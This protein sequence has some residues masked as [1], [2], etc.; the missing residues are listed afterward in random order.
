MSTPPAPLRRV[1]LIDDDDA[2]QTLVARVLGARLEIELVQATTGSAG[3]AA[4]QDRPPDLILLDSKLPDLCGVEVLKALRSAGTTRSVPVVLVTAVAV[5]DHLD[6]MLEAGAS[7]YLTKPFALQR[8][9]EI[10]DQ[11]T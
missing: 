2:M 9:L 5:R 10:I 1:L 6:A 4:A 3:L 11:Y 8:L 7:D